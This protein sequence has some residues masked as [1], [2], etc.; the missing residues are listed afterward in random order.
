MIAIP[1][2]LNEIL[3]SGPLLRKAFLVGGCV[4]DSI[5]GHTVT[6]YDIEVY[7]TD[8]EKLQNQLTRFGRTNI[9]GRSFGTLKLRTQSGM[10]FDFSLPRK[11][12]KTGRGHRGFTVDFDPDLSIEEACSRRDFTIN[13]IMYN[14]F[15]ARVEDPFHGLQDLEKR[16]LRHTS[17]AFAED[18]LRVLRGMQFVSRFNLETAPATLE[19]CQSI[20]HTFHELA[21]E[22]IWG[23]WY[24]WATLSV[25]PSRGLEFLR[26]SGWWD[27]YPALRDLHGTPQ[28]SQWHPEGDVWVHTLHV[29]DAMAQSPDWQISPPARKATLMLSALTHDF[30]KP[31][32]TEMV[33][34]DGKERITSHRHDTVGAPMA[35]EFLSTLGCP[36]DLARPVPPLVREHIRGRQ[37]DNHRSIRRLARR[38]TPSNIQDLC[39][40]MRA[41]IAGRPPKP[42]SPPDW[43]IELEN[44]SQDLGVQNAP[45]APILLGR[46]LME[47]GFKPGP[48]MGAV[49]KSAFEAQLDGEFHDL[50][51]AWVWL[52]ENPPEKDLY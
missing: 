21:S 36:T 2:E 18:P 13:A 30:G 7:G 41:D 12:S 42:K 47:R 22:R 49:L 23:E 27:H 44:Q 39:L 17:R 26:L 40:L 29:C 4:R 37:A 45:P 24:K 3:N 5:L 50:D 25:T 33:I 32:T 48:A 46:H 9:V 10:Q 51:S 34:R 1:D 16:I 28:D 43:L 6:D 15:D 35:G 14:P 19:L 52:E 20:R 8:F 11:D 38:L 31:S